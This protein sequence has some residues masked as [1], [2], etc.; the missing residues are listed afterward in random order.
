MKGRWR[1]TRVGWVLIAILAVCA[2]LITVGS[3]S[4]R[5]GAGGVA[6]IILLMLVSEGL[7]GEGDLIGATGRKWETLRDEARPRD[8]FASAERTRRA[9]GRGDSD[10]LPRPPSPR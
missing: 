6:G 4:V 8:R 9:V 5:L 3:H 10:D 7:S 1:V 2:L